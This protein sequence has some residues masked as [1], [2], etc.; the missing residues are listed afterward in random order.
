MC[1]T[2]PLLPPSTRH[3]LNGRAA[4]AEEPDQLQR[5]SRTRWRYWI[6]FTQGRGLVLGLGLGVGLG[7]D[8]LIRRSGSG[9]SLRESVAAFT[10]WTTGQLERAASLS[11]SPLGGRGGS[12]RAL[13][14]GAAA[15]PEDGSAVTKP[16]QGGP[17]RRLTNVI[18]A[19]NT[20]A[21]LVQVGTRG[22]LLLWGAK[23][24]SLIVQGQLWRLATPALLHANLLHLFVNAY[25]LNSVG[26]TVEATIGSSR[27][28]A[29]YLTSAVAGFT[30][31]YYF[32]PQ[33]SVGASGAIFGLV[34]AFGV[35]L[36]NHRA[37]LGQT[38]KQSLKQLAGMVAIN[39]I[40][41]AMTPSIDNWGHLGGAVGG[42]VAAWL[43]GPAMRVEEQVDRADGR[44]LV[45]VRDRSPLARL[46]HDRRR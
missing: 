11:R 23:I 12:T 44:T 31:S 7:S 21:Y 14:Q 41:G 39:V 15:L 17:K 9:P 37:L 1:L 10:N 25:S 13:R 45:R 2:A 20:L 6:C 4:L 19:A 34:G 3:R 38:G 16:S 18:L 28:L 22:K 40:Y 5:A 33:P 46:L 8:L 32:S 36:L 30:C 43:V 42:A 35:Y 27:F 29:V 24:N 26:P